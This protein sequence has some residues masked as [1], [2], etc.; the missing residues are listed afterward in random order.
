MF[1]AKELKE[2]GL[3]LEINGWYMRAN[4]FYIKF[5]VPKATQDPGFGLFE[6]QDLG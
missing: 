1:G 2:I 4:V 5:M 3:I 6:G